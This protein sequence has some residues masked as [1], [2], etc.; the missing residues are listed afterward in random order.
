M[1]GEPVEGSLLCD[2]KACA[3]VRG[4]GI[5]YCTWVPKIKVYGPGIVR[6]NWL[7]WAQVMQS[8]ICTTARFVVAVAP[9]DHDDPLKELQRRTDLI[10]FTFKKFLRLFCE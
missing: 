7:Q 6:R 1:E 10:K 3:K 2:A 9:K 4:Q 5:I 8:P